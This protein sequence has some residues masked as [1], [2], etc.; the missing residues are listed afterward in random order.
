MSKKTV[1]LFN[2]ISIWAVSIGAL[3]W[4]LSELASFDLVAK[5][6]DFVNIPELATVLYALIGFAG[7]WIGIQAFLGNVNIK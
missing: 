7:A 6:S 4:L 1:K 2:N 3:N 5:F